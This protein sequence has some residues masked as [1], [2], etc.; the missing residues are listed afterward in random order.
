[1]LSRAHNKLGT[2]GLVVAIVAL[3]AALTGVA[4]AAAGL[5]SKQKKEVKNIAKQFAGKPGAAG[6]TGPTG[7]AG[8]QGPKGDTGTK[9]D[10]GD[11]GQTGPNGQAG[12]CSEE[13][14][15]CSLASGAVLTGMWSAVAGG[16]ETTNYNEL[17]LAAI[18]FPVRVSPPPT[19]LYPREVE[20][21]TGDFVTI[22]FKLNDGGATPYEF[23]GLE[24][25]ELE[26]S[27]AKYE[28]VCPGDS[29]GPEAEPGF[30]CI[31]P[32]ASGGTLNAPH[33]FETSVEA[34]NEFGVVVPFEF[35]T[36]VGVG[37]TYASLR[38]SWAVTG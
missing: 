32:G 17:A 8:A 36:S 22:G 15:E 13:N 27:R 35:V 12:M 2:A 5:N 10:K 38:G 37:K 28:A 31:Y 16:N 9:G 19:A 14:P 18:S 25:P 4:F 26:A 20:S 30:L 23:T 3:I 21:E 6:A 29:E 24:T 7:P 33:P 1:M 34:A 11:T